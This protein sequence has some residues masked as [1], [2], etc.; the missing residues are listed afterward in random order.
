[1]LPWFLFLQIILLISW[2]TVMVNYLLEKVHERKAA[3]AMAIMKAHEEAHRG[4]L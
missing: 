3:M 4:Q 1:M 2:L